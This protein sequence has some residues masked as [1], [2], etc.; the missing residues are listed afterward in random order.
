ML[1]LPLGL[2]FESKTKI[3][4]KIILLAFVFTAMYSCKKD[5]KNDP[6]DEE[7]AAAEILN[8]AYQINRYFYS[9]SR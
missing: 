8:A 1:P 6:Q 2:H 9:K 4:K 3:M 5:E 7:T